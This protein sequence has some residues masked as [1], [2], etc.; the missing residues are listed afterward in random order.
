MMFILQGLWEL[1]KLII[2][3]TYCGTIL[4]PPLFHLPGLQTFGLTFKF[5]ECQLLNQT[6]R[7]PIIANLEWISSSF[8]FF[9]LSF[10]WEWEP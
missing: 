3:F 4:S 5:D 10:S 9:F 6:N 1:F 2:H 8:F 7:G